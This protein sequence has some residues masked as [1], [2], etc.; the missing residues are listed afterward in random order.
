MQVVT[1]SLNIEAPR[2]KVFEMATDIEN[3]DRN[4]K[5]IKKVEELTEGPAALGKK[6]RETRVM[7]GKEASEVMWFSKFEAPASF[8]VKADSNGTRY[9]STF[10]FEE[11]SHKET[12]VTVSFGGEPVTFFAKVMGF[13]LGPFMRG[14]V[15]KHL[16]DDL[17][18]LKVNLE[19]GCY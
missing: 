6:W 8:E 15:T 17:K 18:D 13:V 10:A 5:G 2:E 16:L 19:C 7:F 12:K 4:I 1:V 14:M 9:L 3:F 11:I